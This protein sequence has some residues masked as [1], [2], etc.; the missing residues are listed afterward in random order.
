MPAWIPK[1]VF[2]LA[3]K[4]LQEL[5][6]LQ[7][8]QDSPVADCVRLQFPPILPKIHKSTIFSTKQAANAKVPLS[9]Q[10]ILPLQD[11]MHA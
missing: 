9:W 6:E 3:A 1:R 2:L 8:F 5:Q 11:Q 7:E 4:G 10:N